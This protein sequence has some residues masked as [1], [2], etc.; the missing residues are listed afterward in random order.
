VGCFHPY[1]TSARR[2]ERARRDD[3]W[4]LAL[5]FGI[6]WAIC[7]EH[8]LALVA[9]RGAFGAGDTLALAA[10]LILPILLFSKR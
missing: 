6:V 4:E 5:P 2:P 3:R 8:V 10:V 9:R 7:L 1:R